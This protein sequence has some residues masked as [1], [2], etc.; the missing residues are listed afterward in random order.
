[1][2]ASLKA[3]GFF[4]LRAPLLPLEELARLRNEPDYWQ[5]LAARPE[6]LEA[7]HLASPGL[8]RRLAA[9]GADQRVAA[10]VTAYLVRMCTRATPFGLFAGCSLGVVGNHTSLVVDGPDGIARHSRPDTEVLASLVERLLADPSTRAEMAV[11]PNSSR[12]RAAGAVRLIESRV[13]DGRRRTHHLVMVEDDG[14]LRCALEAAA[15]G[16]VVAEV[17]DAVA[18]DAGVGPD[19]ARGYVDALVD[20]QVLTPVAEPAVTGSEPLHH[21]LSCLTSPALTPT[22]QVLTGVAEKLSRLDA[23][24]LGN[25]PSAYDEVAATLLELAG[26]GDDARLVQVDMHRAGIGLTLGRDDVRKLA[27]AVELLRRVSPPAEDPALR[28]FK[29]AFAQR[30]EDRE[31]PLMEALDEEM[32]I[33]FDPST[34]PAADESPLLAGLDL[35]GSAGDGDFTS[36]DATLLDLMLRLRESG[37]Q[38]LDLDADTVE[39][40]ANPAPPPL[41]DALTVMAG[42][43]DAGIE[44]IS[45][46]GPSG[47]QLLGR[48]CHGDPRLREAVQAHLRAEESFA[49]DVVF[50]EII[51][52]PEGRVGNVLARP[53]LR[54]HEL[55]LL[56]RSGAPTGRRLSVDELTVRLDGDRIVLF[57]SRLGAEVRPRMSTAHNAAWRGFGVYRFLVAVQYDGV[58]GSLA[59]DWGALS[60]APSLPRVTAGPLVLSRARWRLAGAEIG[61]V[62]GPDAAA[63]WAM[64]VRERGLPQQLLIADGDNRLYVDTT[65]AALTATAA[66]TLRGRTDAVVEEMLPT[67][68]AKGP[69]GTFAQEIIVP[70]IR[71]GEP[72]PGAGAWQKSS[73]RRSFVPGSEWLYAKI[74]TGTASADRILTAAVAPVVRVLKSGGVIDSWFFLRYHDPGHHLRIRLHGNPFD[75]RDAALLTLTDALSSYLDDGTVSNVAF[76]TYHREIERYGGDA[77]ID[78]AERIHAADSDAVVDLLTMLDGDDGPDARW[79]LCLYAMDSLLFDAGLSLP[80]RREWARSGAAGYRAEYP[81]APNLES[82]I[83][84]RWRTER[85]DVTALLDDT[86]EHPYD[87]G[88]QV[89]Q[90]RSERLAPLLA[91]LTDRA[92]RDRLTQPM[93]S[94]LHSISHLNAVRLL[95]S[96][97]RTHELVLLSFLDRHYAGLLARSR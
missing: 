83:G 17:A 49:P 43:L 51:H 53:V 54:E 30:Y 39:R 45:V 90:R 80:D 6:V 82:G 33:G 89:F 74:Y 60:R 15:G 76:D 25:P 21:V 67:G 72:A 16:A 85:A 31:V 77:G 79:K 8:V 14:P 26:D 3:S 66:K 63:G 41:P 22:S 87:V 20:A 19:E 4:V 1:M 88:R 44:I 38:A 32:G 37:S 34:H 50:A 69:Q 92:R 78:I 13:R 75:L 96:A 48:F 65:S 2:A 29:T 24:G 9:G 35:G 5:T 18:A 28:R 59:W 23:A 42:L 86:V 40:L 7:L 52:L 91:E 73:V 93:P 47:A 57:S 84:A 62:T 11:E 61:T 27:D 95:R 10:S 97:A 70:F 94:L 68:V 36:R 81:D 58:A 46:L 55:V 64:L 12:Y 56:G 71:R